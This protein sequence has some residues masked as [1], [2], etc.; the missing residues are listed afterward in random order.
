[1]Q[2]GLASLTNGKEREK[3]NNNTK[4]KIIYF[5]VFFMTVALFHQIHTNLCSLLV[6]FGMASSA[7]LYSTNTCCELC[8]SIVLEF[9]VKLPNIYFTTFFP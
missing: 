7:L 1:M 6:F 8:N 9:T 4:Q 5:L 3:L 2:F